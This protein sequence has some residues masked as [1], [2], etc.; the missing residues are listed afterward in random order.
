MMTKEEAKIHGYKSGVNDI[1]LTITMD[2]QLI[3]ITDEDNQDLIETKRTLV[4]QNFIQGWFDGKR[5]HQQ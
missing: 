5:N 1:E 3:R 2:Q 4:A